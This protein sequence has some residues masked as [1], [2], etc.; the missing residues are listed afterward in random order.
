MKRWLLL[1]VLL[2]SPA[3]GQ[4]VEPSP[5]ELLSILNER[6][7]ANN[8]RFDAQEKA[9]AA[10]LAAAKEAVAKAEAAAEKRFDSVNEFRATLK[11]QQSTL[12]PRTE[13]DVRLKSMDAKIADN[14]ARIVQIVS[15]AEGSA[16]L[17]QGITVALGIG[18]AAITLLGR[19]WKRPA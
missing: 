8:Q 19:F 9:V 4:G 6:S 15:R 14:E 13:V 11:D 2:A 16:Q 10:A 3:F 1:F 7:T 5:R 18:I 17:W 12:I